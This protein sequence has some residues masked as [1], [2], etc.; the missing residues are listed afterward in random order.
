MTS[1]KVRIGKIV[2]CHGLRGELKVRPA[3]EDATWADSIKEISLTLPKT[4]ARPASTDITATV[5]SVRFQG[6][7]VVIRLREYPDRTA[8]EPLV[9]A[10]LYTNFADLS[11]P[12]EDEYWADD[13]I[14]LSVIDVQTGRTRGVVKD[15]LS[16]AGS[17]FLEIQLEDSTETAVIP[18]INQFFPTVDLEKRTIAV[19]LLGDFLAIHTEPVTVDRLKE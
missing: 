14:G 13:L 8:A 18:F 5:E 6:P 16:S 4:A 19:D 12:Q 2:G 3:S 11:S 9:G 1:N 7:L 10:L 15:L 17:D